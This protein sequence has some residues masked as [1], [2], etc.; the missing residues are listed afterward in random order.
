MLIPNENLFLQLNVER[1]SL[2]KDVRVNDPI[3]S[4]NEATKSQAEPWLER[5][6]QWQSKQPIKQWL[7]ENDHHTSTWNVNKKKDT[8]LKL[9]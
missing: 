3:P 5:N 6:F 8:K 2:R 1:F 4:N 7:E 9:W